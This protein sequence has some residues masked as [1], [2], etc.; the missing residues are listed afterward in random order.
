MKLVQ[1][2][3]AA[4]LGSVVL[5]GAASAATVATFADPS[6]GPTTP[7]FSF[8]AGSGTLTGG[9]S[10]LNLN[11]QVPNLLP[12]GTTFND[13]HF[14]MT[15]LGSIGNFGNIYH[16][17]GGQINFTTAGNAPLLTITFGDAWLTSSLGLGASDFMSN[18]VVFSGPVFNGYASVTNEAFSFSFAN[19]ASLATTQGF[20]VTSSFTSSAD[21]TVPAPGAAALLGLGGLVAVRRRR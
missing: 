13:A 6:S 18:S 12:T 17:G 21:L 20:T 7:L 15:P 14:T 19:P 3:L 10:G 8:N 11:L 9:W 1:A 4:V 16:M 5:V 2:T